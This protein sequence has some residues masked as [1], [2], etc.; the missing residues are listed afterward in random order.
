MVYVTIASVR[1]TS[2]IAATEIDDDDTTA[3]IAEV[4][5]QIERYYNTVFTPRI[6]IEI[7]NGD[8]TNRL[9]LEQNPVLAVRELK[10]DGDT[11]D[12]ANLEIQKESGYIFLGQNAETSIF[13][14]G[15]NEV[16]VKYIYGTVEEIDTSTT[17]TA[18]TTAGTSV[19][20]SVA[21]ESDFSVND[22]I[23]IYG[24]DGLR[25]AAKITATD[26]NEITVDQL[27]LA[28]E[29]GSTV[30]KLEI[31]EIFKK[32]IN[33]CCALA[34]VAR[35]VGQ[36]YTDIVGY[37]LGELQVQKGEPY[38][39]WRETALQL[40]RERDMIMS[41]IGIRTYVV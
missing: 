18:A 41:K 23:E 12:P 17:S 15:Y 6:K 37:S 7:L 38:T 20:I 31:H 4:E 19:A 1:R 5:P 39:Q 33:I 21:D 9:L 24:M 14:F 35:I 8:G 32:L 29:S 36:S 26:T 3:I 2:G 16:I 27:V 10:I 13:R 28:H 22:W 30:V 11:E 34:Q 40:V 25:E